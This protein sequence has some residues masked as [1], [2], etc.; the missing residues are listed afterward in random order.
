MFKNYNDLYI[1][2]YTIII[3]IISLRFAK[4]INL[5]DKANYR[6][7]HKI[8]SAL[9]GGLV[10]SFSLIYVLFL[11]DFSNELN[12]IIIGSILIS[13]VGFVDDKY[14]LKPLNKLILQLFPIFFIIN[15]GQTLKSLGNYEIVGYLDLGSLSIIFSLLAV[16]LFVNAS[17]YLDGKDGNLLTLL[18]S[19]NLIFKF[20]F[21]DNYEISK[22]INYI[23]SISIALLIFNLI[24][25]RKY[26]LFLGDSGSLLI[27]F[28]LAFFLIYCSNNTDVHPIIL[29]S[30]ICIFIYDF[31]AV[32]LERFF[33][34]RKIFKP[35]NMHI[36]HLINL[37]FNSNIISLILINFLNFSFFVCNYFIFSYNSLFAFIN[38][39]LMFLIYL[40]LRKVLKS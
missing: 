37:K 39:I 17:N 12:N 19:I 4:N 5:I 32:S 23:I 25:I 29:A 9:I 30:T 35:D 7:K 1:F 24:N 21:S 36:H 10:F 11:D 15:N 34:K 3:I 18:I 14:D 28:Y 20:L 13:I 31:L 8:D 33:S 2:F 6:K 27:G 26:K 40:Y 16:F 22:I 38:Y